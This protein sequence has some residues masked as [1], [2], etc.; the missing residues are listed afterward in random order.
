M[1]NILLGCTVGEGNVW[2]T[3]NEVDRKEKILQVVPKEEAPE[4]RDF[5]WLVGLGC[6]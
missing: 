5:G 3:K 1:R 6:C 2:D 4:L